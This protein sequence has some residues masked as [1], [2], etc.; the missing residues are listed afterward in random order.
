MKTELFYAIVE[1][2]ER[3]IVCVGSPDWKLRAGPV[4]EK[5]RRGTRIYL[6]SL[7]RW[8]LRS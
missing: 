5:S 2:D 6:G 1:P 3:C 4:G 7:R 8:R